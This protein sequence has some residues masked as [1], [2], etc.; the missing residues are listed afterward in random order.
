MSSRTWVLASC[1]LS[2]PQGALAPSSS[3]PSVVQPGSRISRC[4]NTSTGKR[5]FPFLCFI[6]VS[7][8]TFSSSPS[9]DF[10]SGLNGPDDTTH[11]P[12]NQ[13][14]ATETESCLLAAT[15]Y[16][17]WLGSTTLET[18]ICILA[19][20]QDSG[21]TAVKLLSLSQLMSVHTAASP[22]KGKVLLLFLYSVGL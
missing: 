18:A 3:A 6:F 7:K 17:T 8:G 15:A 20:T 5:L 10:L 19:W 22:I 21:M 16:L 12:P 11:P 1:L 9:A 14:P 4:H 2:L 13:S